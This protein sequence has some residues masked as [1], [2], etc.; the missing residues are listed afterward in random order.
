MPSDLQNRAPTRDCSKSCGSQ[1][2]KKTE[3]PL[4]SG[5][6]DEGGESMSLMSCELDNALSRKHHKDVRSAQRL[7]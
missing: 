6:G 5:H 2:T 3:K 4:A 1:P 7:D